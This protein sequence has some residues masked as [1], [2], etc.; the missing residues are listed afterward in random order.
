M[1]VLFQKQGNCFMI[2]KN[3]Q[4]RGRGRIEHKA[5]EGNVDT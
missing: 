3:R 4:V 1:R 5:E 2:S